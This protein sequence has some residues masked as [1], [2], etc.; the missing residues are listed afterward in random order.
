MVLKQIKDQRKLRA[1]SNNIIV[2]PI[3][4]SVE[5]E[6]GILITEQYED[7]SFSGEVILTGEAVSNISIGDIVY[8]NRYSAT[9]FPYKDKEYLVLKDEDILAV[10]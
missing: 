8:F 5:T 6:S 3:S 2:S 7:K 10:E 1:L 9:P 4:T